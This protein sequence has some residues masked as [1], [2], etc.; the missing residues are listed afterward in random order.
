MTTSPLLVDDF[1]S[2]RK[3]GWGRWKRQVPVFLFNKISSSVDFRLNAL[4][5]NETGEVWGNEYF[6]QG[7]LLSKRESV[8]LL[9]K[10][11]GTVAIG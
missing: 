1:I 6:Y 10:N 8:A 3:K 7:P 4:D 5:Q 2:S 9:L 11:K